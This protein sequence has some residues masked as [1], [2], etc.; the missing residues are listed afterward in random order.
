MERVISGVIAI[1][2]VLGIILYGHPSLFFFLIA[3]IVLIATHEYFSMI[4]NA[5]VCGFPIQGLVLSSFLLGVVFFIPKFLSLFG[6]FIPLTL[7]IVWC[8]REKNV[9]V[10]LDSI[11]YTLFGILY[12]AG[13]G[14]YFLLISNLEGGRQMIVF[15]LLFVWAGDTAAFYVGRK[16]GDR[17]LLEV[18]SPNKTIAGAIANVMG[19]LIAA[20]LASSLFF[21]EIPLIH[22]LIVAFI[23]GIIGQFGDLAESL[24]KRNCQ[25]KDSG[26]LIPG[27][28]GVLDRIDS[29]LF[30][31]PG[32]YCYYQIFLTA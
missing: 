17:K 10:A 5:G 19:T 11:S 9:R 7:F 29:L 30:V 15:I 27:H 22:C 14:G 2:I 25:V 28:G 1:P 6:V 18:V 32:F 21:N 24:I 26:T 4:A 20:L 8:L 3:S 12:T 23:C 31:G 16:L 13:L